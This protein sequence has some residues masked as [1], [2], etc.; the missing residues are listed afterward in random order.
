MAGTFGYEKEHYALS[1]ASGERDLFPAVRANPDAEVV[2]MGIS[3][4]HQLEH[5]TGR[6]PRH[7]AQMLRDA[8]A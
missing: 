8:A 7:L 5:F 2:V 6:H 3:C 4:R 1:K